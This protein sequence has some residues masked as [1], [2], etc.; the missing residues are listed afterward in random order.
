MDQGQGPFSWKMEMKRSVRMTR[1]CERANVASIG[2]WVDWKTG[3]LTFSLSW[4]FLQKAAVCV[5]LWGGREVQT[6]LCFCGKLQYRVLPRASRIACT[7]VL[8]AWGF[9]YSYWGLLHWSRIWSIQYLGRK[10][11]SGA[12]GKTLS[13][14]NGSYLCECWI[15]AVVYEWHLSG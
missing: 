15:L 2:Q 10:D 8:Q 3:V 11:Y 6:I 7:E 4:W 9:A 13:I 12:F 5:I 1:E 14:R